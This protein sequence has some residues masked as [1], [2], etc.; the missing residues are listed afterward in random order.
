MLPRRHRRKPA[1]FENPAYVRPNPNAG[2]Y[3]AV[4]MVGDDLDED[5]ETTPEN[6]PDQYLWA[7]QE[8][9]SDPDVMDARDPDDRADDEADS[10]EGEDTE[11]VKPV[12]T[13][14]KLAPPARVRP[15]SPTRN[16][17]EASKSLVSHTRRIFSDVTTRA[18]SARMRQRGIAL[19]IIVTAD[20][21]VKVCQ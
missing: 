8:D 21:R 11:D 10:D 20:G 14:P 3:E 7:E 13:P 4:A 9:Q 17:A 19:A 1:W 16:L 6:D 12:S 5:Q 18:L 15:T 2:R